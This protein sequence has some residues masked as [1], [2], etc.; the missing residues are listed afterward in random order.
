VCWPHWLVVCWLFSLFMGLCAVFSTWFVLDTKCVW[1]QASAFTA[2]FVHLVCAAFL[3]NSNAHGRRSCAFTAGLAY[4]VW[5]VGVHLRCALTQVLRSFGYVATGVVVSTCCVCVR[6]HRPMDAG[7][8]LLWLC[9]CRNCCCVWCVFNRRIDAGLVL[10]SCFY[11]RICLTACDAFACI[12][13]AHGRRSCAL[14]VL[15]L[16]GSFVSMCCVCVRFHRP[17]DAGLVLLWLC[18]CK[19]CCCVWCVFNRR[20]DA[21]LVLI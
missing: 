21:G 19:N 7:L 13:D 11:C 15:L 6:F 3:F 17:M 9:Y 12:S 18:Y 20:N 8:V 4:C 5:C 2:G 10:I 14:V 1:T 16:R